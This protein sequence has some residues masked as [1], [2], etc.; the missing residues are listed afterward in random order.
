[1]ETLRKKTKIKN[2]QIRESGFE[3]EEIYECE[4]KKNREFQTFLKNYDKNIIEPLNPR[5]A[6]FGG[7]TNITKL[8][9]DFKENEKGEYFSNIC[10]RALW[11]LGGAS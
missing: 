3:L 11:Q 8:T 6:F 9:Y 7:R 4:L 10:N 2:A 5:D 1:M